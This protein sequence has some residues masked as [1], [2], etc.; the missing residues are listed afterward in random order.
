[1]DPKAQEALEEFLD[2]VESEFTG[3]LMLEFTK[4]VPVLR[5]RTD[6]YRYGRRDESTV[7]DGQSTPK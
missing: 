5:K 6:T 2:L 1:M 7:L 3:T 4:G